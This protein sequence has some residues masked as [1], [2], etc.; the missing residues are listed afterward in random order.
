[1]TSLHRPLTCPLIELIALSPQVLVKPFRCNEIQVLQNLNA[2]AHPR[3]K[4]N[5]DSTWA[6]SILEGW[7]WFLVELVH[8]EFSITLP[9]LVPIKKGGTFRQQASCTGEQQV[10]KFLLHI[11]WIA[12]YNSREEWRDI[13]LS[14]LT[15]LPS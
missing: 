3:Q 12:T 6:I 4:G 9:R 11:H 8:F 5:F 1:M 7:L 10:H 15:S 14:R 2:A 13:H